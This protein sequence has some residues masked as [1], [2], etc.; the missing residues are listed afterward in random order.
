MDN[1]ALS[2]GTIVASKK[3]LKFAVTKGYIIINEIKLP[4]KRAMDVKS[5]LNG[6]TFHENAKML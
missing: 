4:G 6:Y 5:L 1:H 2:N 3:E